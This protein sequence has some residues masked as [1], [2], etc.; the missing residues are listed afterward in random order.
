MGQGWTI[1]S[2]GGATLPPP[3][4]RQEPPAS[5]LQRIQFITSKPTQ[6]AAVKAKDLLTPS[7]QSV[8]DDPTAV[9]ALPKTF[10]DQLKYILAHPDV[11]LLPFIPE[12]VSLIPPISN[13][14]SDLITTNTPVAQI[15]ATITSGE[16]TLMKQAGC[17]KP[18]PSS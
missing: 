6:L 1:R 18:F 9:A 13:G 3:C 10:A 16:N 15:M 4:S 11:T 17:P 12:A 8:L 5:G 7:R 14:L 2:V